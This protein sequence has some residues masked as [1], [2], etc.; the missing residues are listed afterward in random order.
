MCAL[1]ALAIIAPQD[2]SAT[3][4]RYGTLSYVPVLDNG[5]PTGTVEF[6]FAAAFRRSGYFG[7]GSDNRPV[8]G[9]IITEGVGATNL[10]FGDGSQTPVLRFRVVAYSA[11]EDWI[12]GEALH[13]GTDDV[14]VR[15]AYTG[16]GPY[17]ARSSTCCRITGASLNNRANGT[18]TLTTTVHPFSSNRS[19]VSQQFPIV[20]VPEGAASTFSVPATD[21]DNDPLRWRFSTNAE[22]GGGNMPSGMSIDPSTGIVTWNNVGLNQARF[23]TV[24]VIVEELDGQ[25][26]VRTQVPV[27]FL[28]SIG[29]TVG[30]P[31]ECTFSTDSPIAASVG[32][33]VSF[34]LTATDPDGD[35]VEV[36]V[37][38]LPSGASMSPSLPASGPSGF[39]TTFSWTPSAA[40]LGATIVLF[41]VTD[42][43]Q[44]QVQCSMRVEVTEEP[45]GDPTD[46]CDDMLTL[47]SW[48][49]V[50]SSNGDGTGHLVLKAQ[51]GLTRANFYN[52][53][54]LS[55]DMS[56]SGYVEDGTNNWVWDGDEGDEPTQVTVQLET[57]D[58]TSGQIRFWVRM[59]DTC[60]RSVDLDPDTDLGTSDLPESFT[61]AQNYPNPFNPTTS[62]VYSL[63]DAAHVVLS[64][65]D[66]LGREV[67]RLVEGEMGAGSH[68]VEWNGT[69]SD[70]S[71]ASS[72]MYLY[73]IQA[74]DFVKTMKMNLVK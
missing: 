39:N 26:N 34:T 74:G 64:V 71:P 21:A 1:V 12:V 52:T 65:Y 20:T 9:D 43:R 59:Y 60:Q 44:N 56:A 62:I 51:Q 53:H 17:T 4:F 7:T 16:N 58:K 25:G 28:L 40:Q 6:R 63:P 49:G 61:I 45:V 24:Q 2:A 55:T 19:P 3:H 23:W 57:I 38:G 5:E 35:D 27:D 36:N 11:T 70:G 30:S 73:R 48:D 14:G 42:Q 22:A 68:T 54:N 29:E 47:P 18:Y 15:K 41:N 37:A 72:G 33:P 66:V 46:E 67:T 10:Q 32:N 13:P 69:F 50:I 8:V 31:P